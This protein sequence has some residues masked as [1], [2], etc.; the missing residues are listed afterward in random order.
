VV[1]NDELLKS[2]TKFIPGERSN[3]LEF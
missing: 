3:A 2:V 1:V